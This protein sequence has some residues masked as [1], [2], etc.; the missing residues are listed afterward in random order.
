MGKPDA[1][2]PPDPKET[3]AAQT[4]TSVATAIANNAIGN[5]N[6]V[7]P[8][9]TLTYDQTGSH[10]FR[11]PFTGKTYDVP[12]YTATQTLSEGQQKIKNQGDAAQFNLAKLANNQS[13]F[14]NDYMAEPFQYGVG[15]HE[16]WAG[17][18][19]DTLNND[20]NS[21][22]LDGL[23]SQLANRGIVSGS[24]A[25]DREIANLRESQMH[26]RSRFMLD[27]HN[28]GMNMAMAERN[29]PINEITALLSGSQVSHPN[30]V[31]A[32]SAQIP[33]TDVA[34]NINSNYNQR[35]GIWQQEQ[36]NAAST[37]GGLFGL[38]G[39]GIMAKPWK[40]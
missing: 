2:E 17:G 21:Q 13:G 27:S 10:T 34:G 15:E 18:L 40:P 26:D 29:Q 32:N 28:T 14:L 3:S 33:T 4:G 31:N 19:Y 23:T 9:G 24:E 36:Q 5:V 35:L 11:D 16:E 38:A 20:G 37:V 30:F 7:T 8:D 12:T 39:A 6:Q 1:P 22:A 25:Y